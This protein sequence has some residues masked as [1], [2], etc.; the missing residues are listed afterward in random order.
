MLSFLLLLACAGGTKT[1]DSAPNTGDDT[2]ANHETADTSSHETADSGPACSTMNSGTDWAWTGECP[3]MRTPCD[4]VVDGCSL[5]ID[6]SADGGMTM[7]MPYSGTISGDTV[8]FG[9]DDSVTGCVGT[10]EDPDKVT[11]TCSNGCSFTLRR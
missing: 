3:Q 2:S 11:G 6:Y 10:I 1:D 7:G 8:T 5:T 9:D 4:I